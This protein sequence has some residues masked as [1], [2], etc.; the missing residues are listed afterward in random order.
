M[1]LLFEDNFLG[2]GLLSSHVSDSGHGWTPITQIPINCA[3]VSNGLIGGAFNG[4]G[5][6]IFDFKSQNLTSDA[7]T[8]TIEAE[9]EW[10]TGTGGYGFVGIG[11]Q[12]VSGTFEFTISRGIEEGEPVY[13]TYIGSPDVTNIV[14]TNFYEGVNTLKAQLDFANNV[15]ALFVNGVQIYYGPKAQTLSQPYGAYVACSNDYT[16]TLHNNLRYNYLRITDEAPQPPV[17]GEWWRNIVKAVE[18][19]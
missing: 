17:V 14:I 15:S 6:F 3:Q 13:Y 16:S 10:S 1:A 4:V 18:T 9:V 8:V 2:T 19:P 11:V 5:G 12:G 7:D